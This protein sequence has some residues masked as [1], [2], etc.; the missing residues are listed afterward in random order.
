MGK[1]RV[2][3][4]LLRYV[5]IFKVNSCIHRPRQIVG[6][7]YCKMEKENYWTQ[8]KCMII[9]KDKK[10]GTCSH[11]LA[12][13][14]LYT[15]QGHDKNSLCATFMVNIYINIDFNYI[16]YLTHLFYHDSYLS[17]IYCIYF[18]IRIFVMQW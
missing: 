14:K 4:L 11:D 15:P 12:H 9:E 2:L 10:M 8:R 6:Y 16:L 5:N 1:C 18:N 3:K 17:F 13:E 7:Y